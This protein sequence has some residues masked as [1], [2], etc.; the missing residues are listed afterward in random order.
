MIIYFIENE[1]IYTYKLPSVPS[2]NYILH[3]Y[4][5][6][7]NKR[8]LINVEGTNGK[9]IIKENDDT[10]LYYQGEIYKELQLIPY[11]F[12]QMVAY[13]T[14]SIVVYVAPGYDNTFQCYQMTNDT[15]IVVGDTNYDVNYS[16]LSEKTLEITL[17]N[18]I[19]SF[20]SLS[21][22]ANIYV[23]KNKMTEGKLNN[24]DEIF[25]NGIRLI[26]LGNKI[27]MNNPDQNLMI[28]S[29]NLTN[30]TYTLAAENFTPQ[31][32]L[33]RD[34]YDAKDYYYKSQVFLKGIEKIDLTIANPP[35]KQVDKKNPLLMTIIP[36]LL[37]GS[38]SILM[39]YF[40]FINMGKKGEDW[41]NNILTIIMCVTMLVASIIWPFVERF[42]ERFVDFNTEQNRKRR[43]KKYL[44]EKEK[45]LKQKQNDQKVALIENYISLKECQE[46]ILKKT[47]NLFSRNWDNNAF[48]EVRLGVGDVSLFGDIIHE[49]QEYKEV[50]DKL[51][52]MADKLI[53]KYDHIP[54]APF[55]LSLYEKKDV[56]FISSEKALLWQVM[57]SIILQ[58]ITYH[59]YYNLKIVIL[60]NKG[61][62]N[63]L[64]LLKDSPF[65]FSDDKKTRYYAEEFEEG[66]F[67][68]DSLVEIFNYRLKASETEK[69]EE[70][71]R[72]QKNFPYYLIISDN[73]NNYHNLR[74]INE[75]LETKINCGFGI[76]TFDSKISNVP[77]GFKN[78]VSFDE[79][80]GHFFTS[81]MKDEKLK[82]FNLEL[83][84]DINITACIN[85]VSN[86]P[87]LKQTT[88]SS[89]LP[90]TLGFL[91]MYGVGKIEQ[92]NIENRWRTS[93]ISQSLQAPVGVDVN[94]NILSL[95]LHEKKH[96]PH[97]LIAGMTGSGKSEFIISYVLSLA[98]NYSPRE[99]QFVL[100][101]YKGGGLAGAFENRKTNKKLPHLVGTITNLDKSEMNRT[102][103][104]INSELHRRQRIFNE[105]KERLNTGTIDIYKYQQ[106]VREGKLEEPLSHLFIIC[107]EFAELKQQQPD[108]MEELISTARIG[109]S[110][111]VHLI[112]ATQKP[113]GVVDDQIWSNSKFKV[114]CKVQTA[115][116][117]TEMINKPDAAFIKEV[118]RFYLQV[119]YDEYF[120]QGQSAY[121]GVNY[122]PS[123]KIKSTVATD[124]EIINN[125]GEIIKS[126][127]EEKEEESQESR[128]EELVNI[129]DYLIEVAK[130]EGYENSQLWLDSIPE[131][132]LYTNLRN[133]YNYE[134]KPYD[135][136]PLIGV[137]DDPA[138][139]RQG[140]VNLDLVERGN[141]FISGIAGS[142]KS[143]LIS[144]M[145]YSIVTNHSPQEVNIFIIDLLT[146][147]LTKFM[148]FPQVSEVITRSD[149]S[150]IN[151]LFYFLQ[152]QVEKRKRY[153]ALNGGNF[154]Y[155]KA[156]GKTTFP[157]YIIV[158]NGI[159]VL[160][161]G[162]EDL[163]SN[164][165]GSLAREVNHYGIYFYVT[166]TEPGALG[167]TLENS[168]STNITMRLA[169]TTVYS[170]VFGLGCPVPKTN[171]GRG[172]I[173]IEGSPYEF[174]AAEIS[175]MEDLDQ[176]MKATK[177][178][179]NQA[180]A[181][182][183][184][185]LPTIPTYVNISSLRNEQ[186]SLASLPIGFEEKSACLMYY[187]FSDLINVITYGNIKSALSF[188]GA[189]VTLFQF[190]NNTKNFVISSNKD[191]EINNIKENTKVYT[192]SFINIIKVLNTNFNKLR[193]EP[194]DNMYIVTI[195]DYNELQVFLK[196]KQKEDP[197]IITLDDLIVNSKDLKNIRYI[198][199]DGSSHMKTFDNYAWYNLVQQNKGILLSKNIEDQE[200]FKTDEMMIE[201]QTINR[202]EAVVFVNNTQDTIKFINM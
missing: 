49:K 51:L 86:T 33:F 68:S 26:F 142:G 105:A 69:N 6:N 16:F 119:G 66:Q 118:G 11:Y 41:E 107:D 198:I 8:S 61:N 199:V 67:V 178:T 85:A 12:Y 192:N 78:F 152:N 84:Q 189:L 53:S 193:E 46:T 146:E 156:E 74:I 97:G 129:I 184:P 75:V 130:K 190:L 134:D 103:V 183:A 197:S 126:I 191:F 195:F 160:K 136:K 45:I 173:E 48:L 112:L 72:N 81:D 200:L 128:G 57:E 47:P 36:S 182:K 5:Q 19:F 15:K 62:D 34:F 44:I 175:R 27:Y 59:S 35:Q 194:N 166:G 93:N 120:T 162:Y 29:N 23:N 171:P 111:G 159:E 115:E 20:K 87:I 158:V 150:K 141:T 95:D 90:E 122:I 73:I 101:D 154:E 58:L 133:A 83:P 13:G 55:H 98:I 94:G 2:G 139:Q 153:Y 201:Q 123:D 9:W 157:S 172:I 14:D 137:F 147:S 181:E 165:F 104:S 125:Y 38:T 54:D 31:T 145:L 65:C 167:F 76:I 176:V 109:R 140:P 32:E 179:L 135:I 174:Q 124:I 177:L 121:T 77:D 79:K 60:T 37:L 132:V 117:S 127:K 89:N 144:T 82:S 185:S 106:L 71:E 3:D 22:N 70:G 96:G 92:L 56:V 187:D 196:G 40:A 138:N 88:D 108:F 24:F 164:V 21:S 43:Y 163:V 151:K 28:I 186:I 149:S 188:A 110:L 10:T 116:D 7:G 161:E 180:Y 100:I 30:P 1:K 52:D 202:D 131:E 143:T 4:D 63:A 148:N 64:Q 102:L 113:S 114:C 25:C 170:T 168:F 18:N 42:Y 17:K 99:V 50:D 155:E 39:G 169:D 80:E 91:E